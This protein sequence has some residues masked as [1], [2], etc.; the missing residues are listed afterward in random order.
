MIIYI[1]LLRGI[2][3]GGHKKI[4]MAELRA[5]L[6]D[7]SLKNVKTYIQSGN[8]IF[9]SNQKDISKLEDK[10][11]KA[12]RVQFGF[13]V[14]VLVR[15]VES[16]QTIFDECPF[17]KEKK[18]KS[19]FVVLNQVPDA[20]LIKEAQ[21]I[22]YENEE[23]IIKNSCIYYYCS[24]GY[25]RTKFSMNAFERKLKVTGTSRNYNTMVKL[26]SLSSDLN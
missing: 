1:A 25:G 6:T 19:Y 7:S 8:V 13:E 22:T 11:K 15:S 17:V 3:V 26:L 10:I 16:F 9:Q 23:F 18:E 12:I 14:P 20:E 21:K 2:N 24:T 5:L 4:P